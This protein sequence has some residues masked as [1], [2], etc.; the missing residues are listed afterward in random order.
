MGVTHFVHCSCGDNNSLLR[1]VNILRS[2]D[3]DSENNKHQRFQAARC[4]MLSVEHEAADRHPG[5]ALLRNQCSGHA[6]IW[7]GVVNCLS[8]NNPPDVRA[9][10][11]RIVAGLIIR[12]TGSSCVSSFFDYKGGQLLFSCLDVE[13][14]DC[15]ELAAIALMHTI[16]KE[17]EFWDRGETSV[18]SRMLPTILGDRICVSRSIIPLDALAAL[19]HYA[20][21]IYSFG[22]YAVHH[23]LSVVVS[24]VMKLPPTPQLSQIIRSIVE[25]DV[26]VNNVGLISSPDR[27]VRLAAMDMFA[28]VLK[29]IALEQVIDSEMGIYLNNAVRRLLDN[30]MSPVLMQMQYNNSNS[31]LGIVAK[32]VNVGEQTLADTR[33]L[34]FL[35]VLSAYYGTH[36]S[37]LISLS[38]DSY[39]ITGVAAECFFRISKLLDCVLRLQSVH[40]NAADDPLL[41]P[42]FLSAFNILYFLA[43]KCTIRNALIDASTSIDSAI[44]LVCLSINPRVQFAAIS[45]LFLFAYMPEFGQCLLRAAREADVAR[46]FVIV[47]DNMVQI[48]SKYMEANFNVNANSRRSDQNLNPAVDVLTFS[49]Y[50]LQIN[51]STNGSSANSPSSGPPGVHGADNSGVSLSLLQQ[52]EILV[53]RNQ[54]IWA[55]I[56]QYLKRIETCSSVL[57]LLHV[58]SCSDEP[59]VLIEIWRYVQRDNVISLLLRYIMDVQSP[60]DVCSGALM[61]LGSLMG[62]IP[63]YLWEATALSRILDRDGSEQ[64]SNTGLSTLSERE[65]Q[66]RNLAQSRVSLPSRRVTA[67][68]SMGHNNN[69]YGDPNHGAAS[70]DAVD[71]FAL[72]RRTELCQH[73]MNQ[74]RTLVTPFLE[75][76]KGLNCCI[77][78]VRLLHTLLRSHIDYAFVLGND[79]ETFKFVVKLHDFNTVFLSLGLETFC[80]LVVHNQFEPGSAGSSVSS[81]N[82]IN[83]QVAALVAAGMETLCNDLNSTNAVIRCRALEAL[84][85]CVEGGSEALINVVCGLAMQALLDLLHPVTHLRDPLVDSEFITH[86]VLTIMSRILQSSSTGLDLLRN[87][88]FNQGMSEIINGG[89]LLLLTQTLHPGYYKPSAASRSHDGRIDIRD[90]ALKTIRVIA[91]DPKCRIMLLQ[92]GF[93]DVCMFLLANS[94]LQA[95]SSERAPTNEMLLQRL[96]EIFPLI[97]GLNRSVLSNSVSPLSS[98]TVTPKSLPPRA[99]LG[100]TPSVERVRALIAGYAVLAACRECVEILYYLSSEQDMRLRMSL[101]KH[102][103]AAAMLVMLWCADDTMAH[104]V[105]TI[106]MRCGVEEAVIDTNTVGPDGSVQV[107]VQTSP[108]PV[109]TLPWSL[110]V[111]TEQLC[112]LGDILD[113]EETFRNKS[114]NV[115]ISI[116]DE[117][118]V[119]QGQLAACESIQAILNAAGGPSAGNTVGM[120]GG[121]G[122][123]QGPQNK[124]LL[125]ARNTIIDLC[126]SH[127]LMIHLERLSLHSFLAASLLGE[128]FEIRDINFRF[129]S[130]TILATVL[131]MLDSYDVNIRIVAVRILCAAVL[132]SR[133]SRLQVILKVPRLQVACFL[134]QLIASGFAHLQ[135][136]LFQHHE[137]STVESDPTRGSMIQENNLV[138][139]TLVAAFIVITNLFAQKVDMSPRSSTA[140]G[141]G[142]A[143]QPDHTDFQD[144]ELNYLASSCDGLIATIIIRTPKPNALRTNETLLQS[145]SITR[146]LWQA[147][148]NLA[149]VKICAFVLLNKSKV[150]TLL[151]AYL[152]ACARYARSAAGSS[153]G[154]L[155]QG[156]DCDLLLT[157]VLKILIKLCGH[158]NDLVGK[159]VVSIHQSENTEMVDTLRALISMLPLFTFSQAHESMSQIRAP[160]EADEDPNE[161]SHRAVELLNRLAVGSAHICEAIAELDAFFIWCEQCVCNG[162]ELITLRLNQLEEKYAHQSVAGQHNAELNVMVENEVNMMCEPLEIRLALIAHV[163]MTAIGK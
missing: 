137:Q 129:T 162:A 2:K 130:P 65:I 10:G 36:P 11:C 159:Q 76:R 99:H 72:E 30:P 79:P 67:P 26:V 134:E 104:M 127:R 94:L 71:R 120:L 144:E 78:A 27:T 161:Y 84:S 41:E 63:F 56:E 39:A 163:S 87:R 147:L 14:N 82:T 86:T 150:I 110:L 141:H 16:T 54:G 90:S 151:G 60:E 37:L 52:L 15:A 43:A 121:A 35:E 114:P 47:G 136:N 97:Q 93:Q 148:E 3:S 1:C 57:R 146:S 44:Q 95:N 7:D 123:L 21:M 74:Y 145:D 23:C 59:T 53:C 101:S 156:E 20:S 126:S 17:K 45:Y 154:N 40:G 107:E 33:A 32:D 89:S 111:Q 34:S 29:A 51:C 6:S 106:F 142:Q 31:I 85:I 115:G 13:E 69:Y 5:L 42:L 158:F 80:G 139:D 55:I 112:I 100:H 25:C 155:V 22:S 103:L 38:P 122:S 9:V 68:S 28:N 50:Q 102:P 73:V 124:R 12:S 70:I 109:G 48:G 113:I 18:S 143:T 149:G 61:V 118:T 125:S 92:S 133:E 75:C 8:G 128:I 117:V 58:L 77:G 157:S 153:A 19:G 116:L 83:T 91:C 66:F 62:G 132:H 131:D 64:G 88:S 24:H 108:S 138:S 49:L 4:L 98:T 105:T 119:L 135:Q 96:E 152:T 46:Y 140:M 160:T 81:I